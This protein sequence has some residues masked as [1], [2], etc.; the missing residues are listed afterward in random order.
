MPRPKIML[1]ELVKLITNFKVS[2]LG[3]FSLY[4][5]LVFWKHPFFQRPNDINKKIL[6]KIFFYFFKFFF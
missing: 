6:K 4:R 1:R 2:Y 3:Q 5:P